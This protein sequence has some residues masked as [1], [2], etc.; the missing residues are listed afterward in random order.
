MLEA[1]RRKLAQ[2]RETEK[3][4]KAI[5]LRRGE[6]VYDANHQ[7]VSYE[8]F[9]PAEQKDIEDMGKGDLLIIAKGHIKGAAKLKKP[10]LLDALKKFMQANP[11]VIKLGNDDSDD[12]AV[13]TVPA[14]HHPVVPTQTINNASP[15]DCAIMECEE[16]DVVWCSKCELWF[17]KDLHGPHVRHAAQTHLKPGR[18]VALR[19]NLNGSHEAG[20][21]LDAP[22]QVEQLEEHL[23]NSVSLVPSIDD[24]DTDSTTMNADRNSTF[25]LASALRSVRK[26]SVYDDAEDND[27]ATNNKRKNPVGWFA[28]NAK[29]AR[30]KRSQENAQIKLTEAV[31]K[32]SHEITRSTGSREPPLPERLYSA[33]NFDTFDVDFLKAMAQAFQ[34]DISSVTN[35]GR[36]SR[37]AVASHLAQE[38]AKSH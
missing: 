33:L 13:S 38:I 35:R 1:Q 5:M 4:L 19:C 27:S 23:T 17:C 22:D 6:G 9:K 3:S 2:R 36:A 12:E 34:V 8:G 14:V 37:T 16:E 31:N 30:A 10:E 15:T 32:V 26:S 11:G 28:P 7:V 18:I 20:A 29:A 21:T 24:S 25:D